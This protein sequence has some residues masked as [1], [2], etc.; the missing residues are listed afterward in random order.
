MVDICIIDLEKYYA[1][2]PD[3]YKIIGRSAGFTGSDCQDNG[4]VRDAD[5]RW[6]ILTSDKLIRFEPDRIVSNERPPICHITSVEIPGESSDWMTIMDT[7]LFYDTASQLKIR[8]SHKTIRINFTGI[9]TRNTEEI[10]YQ[11]RMA[12]IDDSWSSRSGVR[13]VT[14]NDLHPGRYTFELLSVNADGVVSDNPDTLGITV[15]P[16]FFQSNF[17]RITLTLM[18]LSLLVLL[19]WRIRR[20]VIEIRVEEAR[21]QAESY[22]LQL[23][24]V[25]RQFDPHFTFN[26]VTSVGSLIMKGEK[27]KAYNYFIKLSN[28]LRSVLTDSAVLLKPLEQELEFVTRYCELQKLRYSNRFEYSITV[29]PS[30]DLKTQVPKMIIQSFAENALK[31]G[32]ENKKGKGLLEIKITSLPGGTEVTVRDNG[33]GR[34]AASAVHTQGART[35]LKNIASIIEMM[36]KANSEKITF[37]LTDLYDD[38]MAAGTEVKVFL[39]Y[40]YSVTLP[41]ETVPTV[42]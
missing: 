15:V 35:G 32:L 11:Y 28:L 3:Y 30:V 33:I 2:E 7:A 5:G 31:H 34:S 29:D 13:S 25:I 24:S 23:N 39:P 40:G 38:G 8:G 42:K 16:T 17:A 12:G 26:A 41:G 22:R 27:E 20:R 18:C 36:N 1:G 6:W 19:V 14:Y 4:M 21:R 9:S 37:A 10:S